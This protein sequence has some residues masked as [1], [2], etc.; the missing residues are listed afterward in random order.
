MTDNNL[1]WNFIRQC[2]IPVKKD[3]DKKGNIVYELIQ[4]DKKVIGYC[5]FYT[6]FTFDKSGNL[7]KIGIWER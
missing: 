2:N 1:F 5:G 4:D 3:K 6:D 7:I